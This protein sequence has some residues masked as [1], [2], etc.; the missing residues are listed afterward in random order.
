MDELKPVGLASSKDSA[1]AYSIFSNS[2]E[3]ITY[4]SS[5]E[6]FDSFDSSNLRHSYFLLLDYLLDRLLSSFSS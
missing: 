1:I 4:F 3:E 6:T 2:S 5:S